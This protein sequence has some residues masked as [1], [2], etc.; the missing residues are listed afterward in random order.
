MFLI[1]GALEMNAVPAAMLMRPLSTYKYVISSA[2]SVSVTSVDDEEIDI[3]GDRVEL[4]V[5]PEK[6]DIKQ[7]DWKQAPEDQLSSSLYEQK[8]PS[9][10]Y[11]QSYGNDVNGFNRLNDNDTTQRDRADTISTPN[12][13]T[14]SKSRSTSF[15]DESS[16][17]YQDT[18]EPLLKDG[19]HRPP[20]LRQ[21]SV[22]AA[23]RHRASTM[24]DSEPLR[25]SA[26]VI[27]EAD[28]SA[29]NPTVQAL[30]PKTNRRQKPTFMRGISSTWSVASAPMSEMPLDVEVLAI[31]TAERRSQ[32]SG[33]NRAGIHIA[34][35]DNSVFLGDTA[36]IVGDRD[37]PTWCEQTGAIFR[38]MF[39]K[40]LLKTWSLIILLLG[41]CAGSIVQYLLA[42]LPTLASKQGMSASQVSVLLT[43][44]G[45]VEL[46]SRILIGLFTDLNILTPG[47]VV[48]ISQ[49]A[50]GKFIL[51]IIIKA[52]KLRTLRK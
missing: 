45:A 1:V 27:E 33:L 24:G 13:K 10:I 47:Q 26:T 51:Q 52:S 34:Q 12:E 5:V 19:G 38:E 50:I 35:A 42:Y 36:D 29:L 22:D 39:S 31:E 30:T 49:I 32:M 40:E 16:N 3:E 14:R 9:E 23:C 21:S 48:A 2:D 44:S 43:T 46:V 41:S 15:R 25:N 20:L 17:V 37:K 4:A 11:S 18:T 28:D 8:S 7:S 6:D